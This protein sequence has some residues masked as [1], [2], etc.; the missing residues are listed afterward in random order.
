MGNFRLS[1]N[2]LSDPEKGGLFFCES[3]E[4]SDHWLKDSEYQEKSLGDKGIRQVIVKEESIR[5][6]KFFKR[7]DMEVKARRLAKGAGGC[8]KG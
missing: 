4:K 5:Y 2:G 1:R 6:R 7:Y 8:F 3:I